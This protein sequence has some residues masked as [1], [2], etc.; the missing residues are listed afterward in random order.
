MEKPKLSI[1]IPAY[2]EAKKIRNTFSRLNS[3]F[4]Q[5]DYLMEYVF[6]EDGSQDETMEILKAMAKERRDIK[7]L[8]N[9]KNMGKGYSLKRGVLSATGDYILFM[10]ADMSTPL[11]AFNNFE[12]YLGDYDIIMGSRW[13]EE[14]NIKIPQPL[15]RRMLAHI[16]Y[17]IVR[18]FYLKDITDTNCGFK[19]Y[20]K[21]VA[22][23]IFSK[24]LLRGWGFD[25]ELLYIAQ[26][27]NYRIMEVPV[28]WAHGKDSKVNMLTVPIL[29]LIELARIKIN[30]WKRR[31]E[32]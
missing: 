7:L 14:S 27:R 5:K 28:V 24:Q 30:D 16:F 10:D 20:R 4:S 19:C 13:R 11:T 32:K 18:A 1:V 12:K 29:T 31:Y 15:Y 21:D 6:V 26:K 22:H 3:F 25:V 8:V 17:A 2:N 23:D 9:E